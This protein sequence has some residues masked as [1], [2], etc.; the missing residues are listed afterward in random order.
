M[1][2]APSLDDLA[3]FLAVADAGSLTAAASQTGTPLPT[4]S[5]RMTALE[6]TL[7]RRLFLRGASG[8]KLTAEGRRLAEEAG[9]L[10]G[11]SRRVSR[12]LS[13]PDRA[14]VRITAGVWTTHLLA[15]RIRDYWAPGAPWVPEFLPT[16]TMIDIARREAD[17]G[18]RNTEPDQPWLARRRAGRV[19]VSIY[20]ISPEVTGYLATSRDG[21]ATPSQRWIRDN[22]RDEIVTTASD[23]RACL[24]LALSGLGRIA[25]PDE[26]AVHEPALVAVEP[27]I[28]ELAHD[29]WLVSHHDARHD[30]PIRAALTALAEVFDPAG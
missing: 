17:I 29:R 25:L 22:R 26:I 24:D 30:P 4:L 9:D 15:R 16:S 20:A 11:I 21:D 27:P 13:D 19:T 5:R 8:Y 6:R 2:D 7:G 3:L 23:P 18:I 10:R 28:P 14:R 1:K 12:W